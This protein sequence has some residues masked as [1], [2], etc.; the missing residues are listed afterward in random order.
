MT[1]NDALELLKNT[2]V[3][4]EWIDADPH[5]TVYLSELNYPLVEFRLPSS[6]NLI[7][8]DINF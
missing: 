2:V 4:Q 7:Y 8:L 3:S 5:I 1:R 6:I